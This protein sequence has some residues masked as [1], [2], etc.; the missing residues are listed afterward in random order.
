MTLCVAGLLEF[1]A[2]LKL[3][4]GESTQVPADEAEPHAV[5]HL[6]P[7]SI[8]ESSES[9][10]GSV[11][12]ATSDMVDEA[13]DLLNQPADQVVL[14]TALQGRILPAE[15]ADHLEHDS[16]PEADFCEQAVLAIHCALPAAIRKEDDE[17]QPDPDFA[18]GMVEEEVGDRQQLDVVEE[19][20]E[21]V[22][23]GWSAMDAVMEEDY[24][25]HVIP[26]AEML[27]EED[28]GL[29]LQAVT[30]MLTHDSHQPVEA[31]DGLDGITWTRATAPVADRSPA[32]TG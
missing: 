15:S 27:P 29:S 31:A 18:S 23:I 21:E 22:D 20:E 13:C 14:F 28:A 24:S 4:Y 5:E 30:D 12:D 9:G 8:G 1:G 3:P 11:P 16:I 26:D 17:Q 32:L 2:E 6:R 10:C 19:Q 25:H 7:N